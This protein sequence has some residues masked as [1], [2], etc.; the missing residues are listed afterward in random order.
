M[1]RERENE[2][3]ER[4]RETEKRERERRERERDVYLLCLC[5]RSRNASSSARHSMAP[6]RRPSEYV[7][8]SLVYYSIVYYSII[9]NILYLPSAVATAENARTLCSTNDLLAGPDAAL[10]WRRRVE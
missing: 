6:R 8:Y 3:R 2:E 4:E 5:T 7:H 1:K 10:G 9:Y